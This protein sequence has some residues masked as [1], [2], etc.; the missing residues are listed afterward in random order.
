MLEAFGCFGGIVQRNIK[1]FKTL[2]QVKKVWL[3]SSESEGCYLTFCMVDQ[4]GTYFLS[5]ALRIH[6]RRVFFFFFI[7]PSDEAKAGEKDLSCFLNSSSTI[8]LSLQ[9]RWCGQGLW[10]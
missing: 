8:D 7:E 2:Q 3:K 1:L 10:F 9:R 4:C 6:C 5:Y